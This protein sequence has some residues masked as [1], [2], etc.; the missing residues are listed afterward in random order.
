MSAWEA[1]GKTDDWFTPGYVMDALGE[2]FDLDVAAPPEGPRHVA[3]RH[4]ICENSLTVPWQGFVW[5][6]PPYGGRNALA[7][8]LTKFMAHG[9]G[10]ALTP[11]RTSAPWFQ[12][13]LQACDAVLFVNKKIKF[14]RPDGTVGGSPGTGSAIFAAG[15]RAECAL[16]RAQRA[17]LGTCVK[18]M[19]GGTGT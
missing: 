9:N 17:G 5:M 3:T 6:N 7:S 1:S 16:L 14:E 19:T 2:T 18:P 8:W 13:A 15:R 4:W 12:P 10:L 11:D